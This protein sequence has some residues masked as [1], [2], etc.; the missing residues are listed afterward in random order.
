VYSFVGRT[1]FYHL[2]VAGYVLRKI[3]DSRRALFFKVLLIL[4]NIVEDK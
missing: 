4:N 3:A 1:C 2:V